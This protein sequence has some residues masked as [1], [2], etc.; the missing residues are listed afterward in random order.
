MG[1][2]EPQRLGADGHAAEAALPFKRMMRELKTKRA[3]VFGTIIGFA[4]ISLG[5]TTI[6]VWGAT[7]F[8]RTHGWT[9]GD[10]GLRLGALTLVFGPLGAISGGVAA[11]WLAKR[12]R[13]D[14]QP[15]VGL[16]SSGGCLP[17]AL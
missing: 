2:R 16:V 3:A 4:L 8:L 12:G 10:A 14:A 1:V 6:N 7:L 11:D 13:V 9:I 5:A 17:R 15:F